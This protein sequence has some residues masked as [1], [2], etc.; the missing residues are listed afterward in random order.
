MDSHYNETEKHIFTSS[1]GSKEKKGFKEKKANPKMGWYIF[2]FVV[3]LASY[4][5]FSFGYFK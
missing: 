3:F 2:L 4:G 5:F 1:S